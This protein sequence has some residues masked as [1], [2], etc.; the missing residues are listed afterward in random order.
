M[1]DKQLRS[2]PVPVPPVDE[3]KRIVAKLEELRPLVEKYREYET[4]LTELND[5]LAPSLK[6]SI[7]QYAIQ[8]KL[9]PQDPNDVPASVLLD[10]ICEEKQRLVKERMIK[11]GKKETKIYSKDGKWYEYDGNAESEIQV[12]FDIPD[13]WSYTRLLSIVQQISDGT[14][15]TPKYVASGIPFVSV[16]DISQGYLDFSNVKY[17]SQVEHEE[18]IKRCAPSRDDILICRIGTLGKALRVD[19]DVEFSIFVSLGLIRLVLND[20]IDYVVISINSPLGTNWIDS[21]KVGG[22]SHAY[23]IN[24]GDLPQLLIPIP[25]IE[26]QRRIITKLNELLPLVDRCANQS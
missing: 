6:K 23:K 1:S 26:E 24:L 2:L 17:I 13:S 5:S 12:P 18:L 21:V 11:K 15:R 10:R 8:G 3:Q 14:H 19:T 22:E 20:M 16:K 4:R 25:P 7:L 9:V